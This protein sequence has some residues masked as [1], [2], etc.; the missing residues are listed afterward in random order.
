MD[1]QNSV[2]F[3]LVLLAVLAFYAETVGLSQKILLSF[4]QSCH[5]IMLSHAYFTFGDFLYTKTVNIHGR[6]FQTTNINPMKT[7]V[8]P[9]VVM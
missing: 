1:V 3:E 9:V 2:P 8:H 6:N 4:L 7:E 5:H